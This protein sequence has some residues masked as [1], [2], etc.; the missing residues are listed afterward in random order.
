[1]RKFVALSAASW[2]VHA[3]PAL[4]QAGGGTSG[5]TAPQISQDLRSD[6][7]K[8]GYSNVQVAPQSFVVNADDKQGH[9]VVMLIRPDS[10]VEV[11][12]LGPEH[13]RS[14]GGAT[15]EQSSR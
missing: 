13:K 6:L 10:M 9:P 15:A 8:A 12:A 5:A 11:T 7:Q 2:M 14:A 4:A 1:M 3:V